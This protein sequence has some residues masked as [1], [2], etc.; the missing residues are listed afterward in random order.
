MKNDYIKI[1]DREFRVEVN[2]NTIV[3]FCEMKGYTSLDALESLSSNLTPA[4][5]RELMHASIAEGERLDGRNLDLS[6]IELA[7][8]VKMNNI[9]E[10]MKIF[11]SQCNANV[12]VETKASD[13]KKKKSFLFRSSKE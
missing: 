8:M 4:D 12:D 3:S 6:P 1:G 11:S 7:G 5:L 13:V 9:S 2:W 10:F